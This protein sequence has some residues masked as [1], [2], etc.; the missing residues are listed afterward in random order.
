MW[1]RGVE[2]RRSRRSFPAPTRRRSALPPSTACVSHSRWCWF[3]HAP[4]E[5]GPGICHVTLASCETKS[6]RP[7]DDARR[8][9]PMLGRLRDDAPDRRVAGTAPQL[10]RS[11]FGRLDVGV[12]GELHGGG[13]ILVEKLA[14][15]L[16]AHELRLDADPGQV[17]LHRGGMQSLLHNPV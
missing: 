2:L 14:E 17:V 11:L 8:L 4:S 6:P 5:I 3:R 12:P 16:D 1:L 15:L 9:P 10:N 7:G 13:Q